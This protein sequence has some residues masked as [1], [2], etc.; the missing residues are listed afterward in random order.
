MSKSIKSTSKE[1]LDEP[2][3]P[4]EMTGWEITT[5]ILIV[6]F[7]PLIVLLTIVLLPLVIILS[8][9]ALIIYGLF[10]FFVWIYNKMTKKKNLSIESM[11]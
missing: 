1:L 10:L 5:V 3:L 9:P 2:Q 8:I 6:I 4:K 7:S 11:K